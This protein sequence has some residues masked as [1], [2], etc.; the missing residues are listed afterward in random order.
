M[1]NNIRMAFLR[2]A[3]YAVMILAMI[4]GACVL[5]SLPEMIG[6]LIF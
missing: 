4:A 3:V 2:L 6:N 5:L 1:N